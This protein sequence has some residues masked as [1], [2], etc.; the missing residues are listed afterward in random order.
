MIR[1]LFISAALMA[2]L[3][4]IAATVLW[5]VSSARGAFLWLPLGSEHSAA[6]VLDRGILSAALVSGR[7]WTDPLHWGGQKP[8]R[9]SL[10][11]ELPYHFGG[12]GIG[13]AQWSSALCVPLW[14]VAL[15]WFG[16][17]FT[18]ARRAARPHKPGYCVR[19]GYDLRASKGRC[20]E[21]GTPIAA[22]V[23]ATA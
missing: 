9:R 15:L 18:C 8:S 13:R 21:C 4:G 23:E 6:I 5:P 17:A 1:R 20:P 12:F 14:F 10:L 11:E 19:C 2:L 16:A 3:M 7:E 22:K